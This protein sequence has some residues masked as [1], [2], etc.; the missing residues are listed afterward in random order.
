M[1]APSV[2]QEFIAGTFPRTE[3]PGVT[4]MLHAYFDDSGTHAGSQV[5]R[6]GG[7]IGDAAQWHTFERL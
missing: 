3:K 7:L 2:A 1:S 6:M 4:C 5:V